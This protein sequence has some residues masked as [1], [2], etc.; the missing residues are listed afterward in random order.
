M[1][2]NKTVQIVGIDP[3]TYP[4]VAGLEFTSGD[5]AQ[6]YAEIGAGRAIV[7]NGISASRS[8]LQV[9]DTITL[10]TPEGDRAYRLPN[11]HG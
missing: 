3:A 5:E 7:V 8:G 4:S 10:K 9:G 6:A 2:K 1:T 11:A